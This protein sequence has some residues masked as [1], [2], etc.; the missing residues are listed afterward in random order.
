MEKWNKQVFG[1]RNKLKSHEFYLLLFGEDFRYLFSFF[2]VNFFILLLLFRKNI[3]N[4][5]DP[6]NIMIINLSS[7][8]TIFIYLLKKDLI[9][10]KYFY[11]LILINMSFLITLKIILS[12]KQVI[13]YKQILNKEFFKKYYIVHTILF[14]LIVIYFYKLVNIKLMTDKLN[15]FNNLGLLKYTSNFLFPGQLIL[16]F[17]K[18]EMYNY[19][20]K[21]DYLIYILIF[22][23]FFFSGGKVATIT[24][25]IYIFSTLYFLNLIQKN[26]L[27]KKI[28]KYSFIIFIFGFIGIIILFSLINKEKGLENILKSFLHR[29]LSSG[30]TYYMA[31]PNNNIDKIEGISLLNYYVMPIIKPILKRIIELKES[32]YP[33]FQIIEAVYG[34]KIDSF[35]PNTRYDLVWQMNTG[36]FGIIGGILSGVLMGVIRKIETLNFILLEIMVILFVNFETIIIDF[37][38]FSGYLFSCIFVTCILVLASYIIDKIL[39]K[40]R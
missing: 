29:I 10:C 31:Y 30:D 28:N 33:G 23:L 14:F 13:I 34:I 3:K 22:I 15:A 5:F 8:F 38:I 11:Q 39:K 26:I 40:N 25:F 7:C 32:I 35:G 17:I 24:Y 19:R 27:Y 16:V 36:Y 1:G 12:S 6:L 2:I 20:N 37:G 21:T 4:L 18:R 9:L